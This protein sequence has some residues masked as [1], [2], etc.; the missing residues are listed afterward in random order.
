MSSKEVLDRVSTILHGETGRTSMMSRQIADIAVTLL[1]HVIRTDKDDH[2]RKV[3]IDA[4]LKQV[5]GAEEELDGQRFTGSRI[6]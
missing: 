5:E 6:Q 2:M 4:E 3:A 1:G